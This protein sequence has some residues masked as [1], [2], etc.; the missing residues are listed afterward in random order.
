MERYGA[1]VLEPTPALGGG[2]A[3][4]ALAVVLVALSVVH[5][6]GNESQLLPTQKQGTHAWYLRV[7]GW[8]R[9]ASSRILPGGL[10]LAADVLVEFLERRLENVHTADDTG[11]HDGQ[12]R[13]R[14]AHT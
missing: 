4:L 12:R 1:G 10:G 14:R 9:R 6:E 5:S 8:L 13:P 7:R 2:G 3:A 11:H